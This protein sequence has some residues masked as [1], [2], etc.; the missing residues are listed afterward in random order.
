MNRGIFPEPVRVRGRQVWCDCSPAAGW[1][2][3][4]KSGRRRVEQARLINGRG[5]LP[6]SAGVRTARGVTGVGPRYFWPRRVR[7]EP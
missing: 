5:S 7:H 1:S 2:P 4:E 3:E 6:V